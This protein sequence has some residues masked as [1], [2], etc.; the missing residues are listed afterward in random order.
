MSAAR[1]RAT[2]KENPMLT[3]HGTVP[4]PFAR[5]VRCVLDEKG[6]PYESRQLM[7]FPKTPELL[8]MNPLGQIPILQDGGLLLPDS[9]VICAYVEKLHPTPAVYPSDPTDFA[10]TLWLEEYSDTALSTAV[11]GVFFQRFVR[12][13]IFQQEPDEAVVQN[14][15]ENELPTTLDYLQGEL[16]DRDFLVGDTFT[17]ADVS[18]CTQLVNLRH[19]GEDVDAKRWPKLA[20]YLQSSLSRPTLKTL[21]AEE[22]LA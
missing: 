12:K 9:S 11:G 8:A 2:S 7:P 15:L 3:I 22:G 21:L 20:R 19:A 5:K 4:S 1:P 6:V 18:V 10:R 13:H 17:L 16:G 14:A